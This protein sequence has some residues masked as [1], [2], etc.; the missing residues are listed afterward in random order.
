MFRHNLTVLSSRVKNAA[1]SSNSLPTFQHNLTVLSS[2]VKNAAYSSNSLPTFR[3]NLS[4]SS[5]R[6]NS[7]FWLMLFIFKQMVNF[8]CGRECTDTRCSSPSKWRIRRKKQFCL[9][10]HDQWNI[11]TVGRFLVLYRWFP[12]GS[13]I[14]SRVTISFQCTCVCYRA[15]T[16]P[17]WHDT[18]LGSVRNTF[19]V[20]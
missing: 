15:W 16:A 7:F 13:F 3:D 17:P 5:S 11:P 6:V 14:F 2:R 8:L 1:Y 20:K 12:E 19:S 10:A 4:F 9:T 18:S